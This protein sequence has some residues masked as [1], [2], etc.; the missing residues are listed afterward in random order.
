MAMDVFDAWQMEFII[1]EWKIDKGISTERLQ[2][3]G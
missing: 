1:R 3:M 2:A